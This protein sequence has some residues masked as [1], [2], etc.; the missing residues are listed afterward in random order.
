M[1][2]PVISDDFQ[3]LCVKLLFASIE[4][5]IAAA[6]F[7]CIFILPTPVIFKY[8]FFAVGVLALCGAALI[9]FSK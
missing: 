7:V 3:E 8:F 1:S 9:L 4:L 5:I 2:W 6:F